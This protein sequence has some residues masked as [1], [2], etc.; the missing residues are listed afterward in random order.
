M[1]LGLLIAAAVLAVGDWTAVRLRLFRIE[2]ALKPLTL[3]V[4]LAAAASADLGPARPWMLAGLAFGLVGDV[5]LLGRGDDPAD[6]AFLVGL[7]AFLVGHLA[8][9]VAF[10]RVGER[11][12]DVLAG[13]LIVAGVSA[14]ALPRV[15]RGAALAGGRR[16]AGAVAGYAG[17]L[18]AMTVLGVGTG[19]AAVAAG[20]VLFLA[21]DTLI[22]RERFVRPVRDGPLL[23]IVSYHLAQFLIV[24]GLVRT[25]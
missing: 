10:L 17:V 7:G 5:A 23:V 8:Y 24:L 13:A 12:I 1:T 4:L 15:L 9:A 6:R 3:A 20:G 14:L 18:A 11:G 16:L 21:S 19:I 22:A 2:Y 25:F